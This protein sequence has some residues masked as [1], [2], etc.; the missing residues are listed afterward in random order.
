MDF[1]SILQKFDSKSQDPQ[2]SMRLS[3]RVLLN[4]KK[5]N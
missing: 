3:S 2:D 5:I 4:D 1:K